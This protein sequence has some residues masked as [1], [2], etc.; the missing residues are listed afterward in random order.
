MNL[1]VELDN[2][3]TKKTTVINDVDI[4][5]KAPVTSIKQNECAK[6]KGLWN[7]ENETCYKYYVLNI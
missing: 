3:F 5:I 2:T 6:N 7:Y 1:I 4:F